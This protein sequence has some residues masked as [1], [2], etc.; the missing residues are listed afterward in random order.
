MVNIGDWIASRCIDS[1]TWLMRR[2]R[3]S[4]GGMN[5]LIVYVWQGGIDIVEVERDMDMMDWVRSEI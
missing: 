3:Y 4:T 2:A 1:L 5:I